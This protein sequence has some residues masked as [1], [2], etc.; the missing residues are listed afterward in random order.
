VIWQCQ[1]KMAVSIEDT[2]V[3]D[4]LPNLEVLVGTYEEFNLGFRLTKNPEGVSILKHIF[5][6]VFMCV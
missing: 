1:F 5:S 4:G 3:K 2:R 6:L